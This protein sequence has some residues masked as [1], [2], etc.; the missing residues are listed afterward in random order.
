MEKR[1]ASYD[2][3]AFKARFSSVEGLAV[4]GTA[5][6][7]AA[8]L[9]FGRQE[10]VDA[11]QTMKPSHFDKSMTSYADHTVWQDVYHV[12]HS[13]ELTLYIKFTADTVTEFKLLSFEEKEK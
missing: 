11:I 2:L 3:S 1:K 10:I 7:T 9:G 12:P 6:K 13:D 8:E 5:V 4:T